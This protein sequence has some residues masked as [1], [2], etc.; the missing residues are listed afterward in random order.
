[1]EISK[2]VFGPEH[3]RTIVTLN[4]LAITIQQQGR[5]AESEPLNRKALEINRRTLGLEHPATLASMNNLSI[6]LRHEGKLQ[7]A[8]QL[9]RQVF[10]INRRVLGPEHPDTIGSMDNLLNCIAGLHRYAE[11]ERFARQILEIK[12]RVFGPDDISTADAAYDLGAFLAIEGKRD[13]AIS[14]L[15]H[16]VDHGL[17]REGFTDIQT[18]PAMK[19]LRGDPRFEAIV[20][21]AKQRAAATQ[22]SK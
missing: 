17:R 22:K 7:E 10:E 5:Y 21:D 1:L 8:E 14:V 9:N 16:V 19:S 6:D 18:N 3:P 20:A 15:G 11:A 13:E 2:R 4:D 12:R